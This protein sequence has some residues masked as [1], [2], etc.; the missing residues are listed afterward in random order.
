MAHYQLQTA[1]PWFDAIWSG[2]RTFH[3]I[4]NEHNYQVGDIL[5][6]LEYYENH[7]N[8]F[9]KKLSVKITYLLN[10]PAF[11]LRGFCVFSFI[12]INRDE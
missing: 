2:R 7:R 4:E 3:I 9:G 11:I 1:Q 5:E 8:P 6:I 12:I 10:H